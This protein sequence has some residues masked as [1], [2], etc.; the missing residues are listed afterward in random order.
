MKDYKIKVKHFRKV[1]LSF[2]G[3]KAKMLASSSLGFN[4]L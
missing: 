4:K 1:K 3:L 2:K